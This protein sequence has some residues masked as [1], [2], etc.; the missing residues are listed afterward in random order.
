MGSLFKVT[1]RREGSV[2]LPCMSPPSSPESP[3]QSFTLLLLLMS[4][5]KDFEETLIRSPS[6]LPVPCPHITLSM[7]TT[8]TMS[9]SP[10]IP[11][12]RSLTRRMSSTDTGTTPRRQLVL[13][14]NPDKLKHPLQADMVSLMLDMPPMGTTAGT[15]P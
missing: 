8:P 15:T 7:L 2:T 4:T 6:L 1:L 13:Q 12:P 9:P 10:L 3:R 14:D 5:P 11:Q